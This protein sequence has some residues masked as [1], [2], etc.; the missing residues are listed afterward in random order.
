V[1][2]C[3]GLS[4]RSLS[5][6]RQAALA[7]ELAATHAA[8]AGK[9]RRSASCLLRPKAD[10][11]ERRAL[12][13]GEV[14]VFETSLEV[15]RDNAPCDRC[16]LTRRSGRRERCDREREWRRDPL[17]GC[18][19]RSKY[20]FHH[21][22]PITVR[23]RGGGDFASI[24]PG[25]GCTGTARRVTCSTFRT[26]RVE[27]SLGDQ[28]DIL[29]ASSLSVP[30]NA[31][32][33]AGDDY[34]VG[35]VN[36]RL[37]GDAGNDILYGV[38]GNNVL[39]GGDGDDE[40]TDGPGND[41][42]DGGTGVDRVSYHSAPARVEVHL[43]LTTAQNTLGSGVDTILG[44]ESLRGSDFDDSLFGDGG[45]NA[46]YGRWGHDYIEGGAGDDNLY[47]DLGSDAIRGGPGADLLDGESG[48][49]LLWGDADNDIIFSG[50]ADDALGIVDCGSGPSDLAYVDLGQVTSNCEMVAPGF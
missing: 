47:G 18:S 41:T 33:G 38:R 20:R 10:Q 43:S 46:I 29:E 30:V 26:N 6:Q 23:Y 35:G 3:T 39:N 13:N 42:H 45:N 44:V 37:S 1:I 25:P 4:F 7:P 5:D 11:A 17:Y 24:T 34:I 15:G 19:G 2:Q 27:V 32:G 16:Y 9:R 22:F 12:E 28:D 21:V 8:C 31:S 14:D 48:P 36:N 40:L 50:L 49:D